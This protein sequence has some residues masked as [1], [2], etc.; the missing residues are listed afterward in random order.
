MVL[1]ILAVSIVYITKVSVFPFFLFFL[2]ADVFSGSDIDGEGS[3]K[4][5]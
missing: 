5:C 2:A 1:N 3:S 4:M